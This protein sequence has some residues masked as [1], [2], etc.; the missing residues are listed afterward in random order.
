MSA[1]IETVVCLY[2]WR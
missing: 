1:V 2:I